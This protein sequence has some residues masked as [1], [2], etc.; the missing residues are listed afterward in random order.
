MKFETYEGKYLR[1]PPKS[2]WGHPNGTF[3]YQDVVWTKDRRYFALWCVLPHKNGP[4]PGALPLTGDM[5]ENSPRWE[6]DGKIEKP[7]L[8]PSIVTPGWHGFLTDG[9]FIACE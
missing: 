7:T 8:K 6:W 2:L 1:H 3:W 5:P 9:R 4:M